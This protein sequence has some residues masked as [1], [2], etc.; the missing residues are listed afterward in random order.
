VAELKKLLLNPVFYTL[1]FKT[2]MLSTL[3]PCG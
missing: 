3:K 1:K 2:H